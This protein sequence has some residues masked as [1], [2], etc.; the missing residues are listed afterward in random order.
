MHKD[1]PLQKQLHT[2]FINPSPCA[3]QDMSGIAHS[4]ANNNSDKHMQ[5]YFNRGLQE[6]EKMPFWEVHLLA[7]LRRP[8][9]QWPA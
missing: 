9:R 3:P 6:P 7:S 4:P 5:W 8:V 1:N 2:Q